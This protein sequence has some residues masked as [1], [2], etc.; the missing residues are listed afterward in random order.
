[1]VAFYRDNEERIALFNRVID[2][3]DS[4]EKGAVESAETLLGYIVPSRFKES[5]EV[6]AAA[7]F[8]CS[9][10]RNTRHHYRWAFERHGSEVKCVV[11]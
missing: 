10:E 11:G 6:V 8:L 5:G 3:R 1:M 2:I 4:S 9:G 7:A